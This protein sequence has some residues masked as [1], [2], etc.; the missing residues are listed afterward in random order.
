MRKRNWARFVMMAGVI[1]APGLSGAASAQNSTTAMSVTKAVNHC[2]NVVHNVR[3]EEEFEEIYY[4]HFDA[5]YNPITGS[6]RN[7]AQ[8]NGD[9]LALFVFDKRM[10]EQGFPLKSS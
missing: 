9:Q 4:I 2:V 10:A 3:P 5:F 6:I 1:A 8:T 7:N